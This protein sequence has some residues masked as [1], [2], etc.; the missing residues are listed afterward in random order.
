[1]SPDSSEEEPEDEQEEDF[2]Q[3]QFGSSLGASGGGMASESCGDRFSIEACKETEMLNYLIERFDSVGM[4]E[5]KA[6]KIC[7][8][9]SVSQLLSNIRSQCISHAALV[10]QGALTQPRSPLQQSLLV[11]YML[12]RNLPYG[13]IQELARM[14]HQEEVF[15]QIFVPILQGLGLAVK[16]CSF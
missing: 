15:R 12:C 8:H 13:F 3:F 14:T 10:L 4:E 5:R 16:E 2:A 6:P 9:P 1:M 7:S 11:P